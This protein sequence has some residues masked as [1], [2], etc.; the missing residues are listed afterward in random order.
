M[1]DCMLD[2]HNLPEGEKGA[3]LLLG[4]QQNLVVGNSLL[5]DAGYAATFTREEVNAMK[6]GEIIFKGCHNGKDKLS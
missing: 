3:Y 6:K 4:L 5:Y 2:I 1:H